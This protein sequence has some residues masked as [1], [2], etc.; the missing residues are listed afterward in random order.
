MGREWDFK[1]KKVS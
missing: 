1:L